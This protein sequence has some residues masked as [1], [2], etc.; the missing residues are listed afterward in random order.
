MFVRNCLQAGDFVFVV[1]IGLQLTLQYNEKGILEKVFEGYTESKSALPKQFVDKFISN[2]TAPSRIAITGGT[3]WVRG[4]LYTSQKLLGDPG[5]MPEAI[6]NN[7]KNA[8]MSDKTDFTFFAGNVDS[9]A[10]MFRGAHPIRNWLAMSKFNVLPGYLMPATIT[11]ESFSNIV[12]NGSYPFHFP[13]IM[14]YIIYR[15]SEVIYQDTGLKQFI[16]D[17]VSKYVDKGGNIKAILKYKDATGKLVEKFVDY[18]DAV[19][20]NIQTKTYIISDFYG[21]IIYS[22]CSDGK[23]R[24]K[25]PATLTCSMCGKSF[26]VPDS[27]EVKCAD[28]HCISRMYDDINHFLSRMQLPIFEYNQFKKLAESKDLTSISDTLVLDMFKDFE[29]KTTLSQLLD[30]V[31][32][33]HAIPNRTPILLLANKCNNNDRTIR[34]YLKHPDKMIIDFDMHGQWVNRLVEW[35][36]DPWN[37]SEIE[38]ILDSPNVELSGTDMKFDGAPI[39][40]DKTIMI[41][42]KFKHGDLGEIIAILQSYSAKVVIGYDS[43]VDCIVIG[44]F[45]EDVDSVAVRNAKANNIPVY[46]ESPFFEA[47]DIDSDLSENL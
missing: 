16:V 26:K 24:D 15:G 36:S 43:N 3:T 17:T 1:P 37:A 29:I 10:T 11:K 40:R 5:R 42:G 34:Y 41:T 23:K 12:N 47:Y 30:A 46:Q 38:A 27:G 4:V 13:L 6:S 31:I 2:R 9:L 18:S 32:P 39:F 7:L 8:Y 44:D 22:M 25:R 28:V 35:L 21:N 19:K 20:F 14:S 33:V 45:L